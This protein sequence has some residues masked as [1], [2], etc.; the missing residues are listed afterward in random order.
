MADQ[1]RTLPN[2][3]QAG[4][5]Q[6]S[7]ARFKDGFG[8]SW[9]VGRGQSDDVPTNSALYVSNFATVPEGGVPAIT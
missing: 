6:S 5:Q 7:T 2:T 9:E 4:D 1:T 8:S 3:S